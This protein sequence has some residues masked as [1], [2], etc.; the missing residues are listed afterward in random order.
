MSDGNHISPW[1][2]ETDQVTLAILGKVA[3][4]AAELSARASRCIIQGLSK[5]DPDSLR[6]NSDELVREMSDVLAAIDNV[7]VNLDLWQDTRRVERKF[8][9]YQRWLDLIKAGRA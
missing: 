1:F 6:P 9:G 5:P 3:E 4:E 2:P 7:R 8:S